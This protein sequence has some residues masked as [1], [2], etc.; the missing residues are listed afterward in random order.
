VTA[1]RSI[2]QP[3]DM[4]EAAQVMATL[5]EIERDLAERQNEHEQ[6]ARDKTS[7]IR[8]WD[9]RLA[10][11]LARA[12]GSDAHSRKAKALVA[13]IEQDDLYDRLKAAESSYAALQTVTKTIESRAMVAMA[14]LKAHGRS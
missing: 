4:T 3:G 10:L 7:L 12:T 1:A 9:Y 5:E 2:F 8:D 11:H 13:A 6:V 14:I